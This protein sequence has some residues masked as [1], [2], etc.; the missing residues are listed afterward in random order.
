MKGDSRTIKLPIGKEIDGIFTSPPYLGLIDYH[1]QHRYAYDLFNFEEHTKAEI[2]SPNG[3]CHN[4]NKEKY[5][6][7]IIVVLN[8]M[9]QN[10]K[11]GAK[12]FIVVNDKRNLYPEIAE[13]CNLKIIALKNKL[14]KT[15]IGMAYNP[16]E[17]ETLKWSIPLNYLKLGE[18]LLVGK[19]FWDFLGGNGTY[20]ELL[21]IFEEVGNELKDKI[22]NKIKELA[23]LEKQAKLK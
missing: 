7:D 5:K 6:Q 19:T 12:I 20:D 22:E 1:D 3:N 16:Y 2:G 15:F 8:N 13:V 10:M 4:N 14:V 11:K 17:S 21:T 9:L 18:D 23:S